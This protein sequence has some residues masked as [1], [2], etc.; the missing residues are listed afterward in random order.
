MAPGQFCQGDPLPRRPSAKETLCQGDPLPRRHNERGH[1]ALRTLVS[2]I[3]RVRPLRPRL[4]LPNFLSL[5]EKCIVPSALLSAAANAPLC[6]EVGG[7]EG[8]GLKGGSKESTHAWQ[9]SR[10][11][12]GAK[13]PPRASKG[14]VAADATGRGAKC[15]AEG[16]WDPQCASHG[17]SRPALPLTV[18]ARAGDAG[19]KHEEVRDERN[20]EDLLT[21]W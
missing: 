3:S 2:C 15:I 18:E 9:R 19:D 7:M 16:T 20:A 12:R 14:T 1:S 13:G 5:F 4:F 6:L 10:R 21:K 8:G 11:V 17:A